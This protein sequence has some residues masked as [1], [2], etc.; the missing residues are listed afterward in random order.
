MKAQ[1]ST[2][3]LISAM[4]PALIGSPA[5]APF[6]NRNTDTMLSYLCVMAGQLNWNACVL[7]KQMRVFV[8][9]PT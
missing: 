2:G 4:C 7:S 8:W 3:G 1:P 6:I 5:P 9:I